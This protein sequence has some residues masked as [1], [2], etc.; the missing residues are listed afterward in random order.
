[1]KTQIAQ[2]AEQ[3]TSASEACIPFFC[4]LAAIQGP[5]INLNEPPVCYQSFRT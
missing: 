1:M 5:C 4:A 2:H 3:R